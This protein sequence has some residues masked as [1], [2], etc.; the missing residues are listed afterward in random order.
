MASECNE[1]FLPPNPIP[2]LHA[3]SLI[4]SLIK[5]RITDERNESKAKKDDSLRIQYLNDKFQN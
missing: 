4:L 5:A 2:S 1:H 3:H